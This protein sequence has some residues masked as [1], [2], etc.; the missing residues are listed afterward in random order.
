MPVFPRSGLTISIQQRVVNYCY[1]MFLDDENQS[2]NICA[3]FFK[4]ELRIRLPWNGDLQ[5]ITKWLEL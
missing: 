5:R 1:H 3:C 4:A 2:D